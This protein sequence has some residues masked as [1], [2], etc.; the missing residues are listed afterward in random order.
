[1]DAQAIAWTTPSTID[2]I[3]HGRKKV[4]TKKKEAI[5]TK[6]PPWGSTV[7]DGNIHASRNRANFETSL[8]NER[9][10]PDPFSRPHN[11]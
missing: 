7:S 2:A 1:M 4:E 11:R 3:T 8:L 5:K 6:Q 10:N 9:Q